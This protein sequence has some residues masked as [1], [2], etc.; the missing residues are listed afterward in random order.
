MNLDTDLNDLLKLGLTT[1][2]SEEELVYGLC[3]GV[4]THCAEDEWAG[5]YSL[6]GDSGL[7]FLE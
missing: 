4:G 6:F 5:S 3:N 2:H 7:C 1:V